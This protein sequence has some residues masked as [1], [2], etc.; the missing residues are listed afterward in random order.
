MIEQ[1]TFA[2]PLAHW[3][4]WLVSVVL[5]VAA[6]IDGYKLKV[7]NWITFPL[8]LS[9]WLYG[10]CVGGWAGLG[11][12]LLGT[13]VGLCCYCRPMQSAEWEPVMSNC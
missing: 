9:G 4:V 6:G 7:P 3:P 11:A 8:V 1:S 5:V 13:V 2:T 12:S 10:V